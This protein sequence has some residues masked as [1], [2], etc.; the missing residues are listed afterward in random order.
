MIQ[1]N[2]L[3][4]SLLLILI[5]EYFSPNKLGIEI[6]N[7]WIINFGTYLLNLT[8]RILIIA[9][10][11]T[12]IGTNSIFSLSS[13]FTNLSL[14][15]TIILSVFLIDFYTYWLHRTMHHVTLLW[16]AHLVHHSDSELDVSTNFRHHPLEII[17]T[18]VPIGV[19]YFI[20][21]LPIEGILAYG[22]L[23]SIIQAFH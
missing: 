9:P 1:N 18:S 21:R 15:S 17:F 11:F 5:W 8:L 19:L 13:I 4:L 3:A 10:I 7:R 6:R 23:N 14:I 20:I 2:Y 22:I 16:R 12:V